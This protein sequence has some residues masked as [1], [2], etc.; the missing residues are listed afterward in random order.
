MAAAECGDI[1]RVIG[2]RKITA[3]LPVQDLEAALRNSGEGISETLRKALRQYNH[4]AA[5]QRLLAAQGQ[6]PFERDWR[7][8]RGKDEGGAGRAAANA[9]TRP[10]RPTSL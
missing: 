5:S 1:R 4:R 8:L 9:I 6:V 7:D 2:M 3:F 10:G